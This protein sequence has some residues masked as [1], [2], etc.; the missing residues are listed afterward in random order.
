M[1]YNY[2]NF[3]N[4]FKSYIPE[5]IKNIISYIEEDLK[6]VDS[7]CVVYLDL[8]KYGL[9]DNIANVHINFIEDDEKSVYYS[10]VNIYDLLYRNR[11]NI[12]IPIEIYDK[13]IDKNKLISVVAHEIRHIYDIY[14]IENDSDMLDFVKSLYVSIIKKDI[15]NRYDKFLY[16]VYLTLE[17]ELIARYTMLYA[18]FRNCDCSKDELYKLFESSYLYKF[19]ES[20]KDFDPNEFIDQFSDISDLLN[21][22]KLFN[23]YFNGEECHDKKDLIEYYNKWNKFFKLKYKE[24]IEKSYKEL[25]DISSKTIKEIFYY[26]KYSSYNEIYY[27]KISNIFSNILKNF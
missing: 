23:Q 12:I 21:F 13:K 3:L 17:H 26:D 9:L 15:D 18:Q 19:F 2:Q 16:L 4:E 8:R 24:Y 1:I 6:N 10:N 11:E 20:L 5:D 14:T 7:S 27:V 22:T 25:D